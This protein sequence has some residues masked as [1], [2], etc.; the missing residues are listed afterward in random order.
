MPRQKKYDEAVVIEKSMQLFWDN[1]YT[2]TSTRMLEKAM[3][4]NLFSIYASFGNKEGVL[5]ASVR[6]YKGIVQTALLQ[7]LKSAPKTIASIKTFFYDFLNFSKSEN[8]YRGCLLINSVNELGEQIPETIATEIMSFSTEIMSIFRKILAEQQELNEQQ[9]TQYT[10]YLFVAL[11][12]LMLTSKSNNEQMIN[13]FIELTFKNLDNYS[14][15]PK[16]CV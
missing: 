7:P 1:G 13:D 16:S 4:I 15:L 5:L 10:N 12:G 11:Q 3:G 14:A 6:N 2:T 8:Q 9:I